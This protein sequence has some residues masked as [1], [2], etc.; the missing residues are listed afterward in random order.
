MPLINIKERRAKQAAAEALYGQAVAQA[1]RPEFYRDLGV[2]DSLDGR[3]DMI[4]LHVYLLLNRLRNEGQIANGLAQRLFDTMF[5]DMDRNLRELGV[6]DLGVGRR[7]KVM[8]KALYGRIAAYEAGLR[9]GDGALCDALARNLFGTVATTPVQL[10]AFC[11]Y[12][13]E[14]SKLLSEQSYPNFSAGHVRF[15]EAPGTHIS[16]SA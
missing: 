14:Q 1:R 15:G 7:V 13:R 3:F 11:T 16:N 12:L 4:A 2:P 10:A 8:A 9:D 6:G 5:A